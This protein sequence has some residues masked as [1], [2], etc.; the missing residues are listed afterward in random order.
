MTINTAD[1]N[2]Q[3][4]KVQEQIETKIEPNSPQNKPEAKAED[5]GVDP[6]WRAFREARKKDRAE[7]EAA[8]RR[9]TEKEAEAAALRAAMEAAFAKGNH[10]IPSPGYESYQ[11][12]ESE[13]ERI[14]KR[15][16]E[17]IARKEAEYERQRI[18]QEQR[19]YPQRLQQQYPDFS[20]VTTTE[21][22]DYLEYHYPEVAEVL[23]VLPDGFDKWSKIYKNVKKFV[24]NNLSSKKEATRA[25]S[26]LLKPKSISGPN[27]MQPNEIGGSARLTEEKRAANWARMQA[28]LRSVG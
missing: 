3:E 12:E 22:L 9:A 5:D 19:D 10:Q 15:V 25:E 13:D 26:N 2:V 6:N 27:A 1:S 4:T 24:P 23:K 11:Q 16:N 21:N 14:E 20:Q 7:R 8:E 18:E 17:I 28:S